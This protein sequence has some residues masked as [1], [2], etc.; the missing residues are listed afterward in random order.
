MRWRFTLP[1]QITQILHQAGAEMMMPD[2][3]DH[4]SRG[5]WMIGLRQPASKGEPASGLGCAIRKRWLIFKWCPAIGQHGGNSGPD[6][7]TRLFVF[8]TTPQIG[9]R[10]TTKIP[11]GANRR[12][13]YQFATQPLDLPF[14]RRDFLE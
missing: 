9:R 6:Q 14:K 2:P 7:W 3:V 4:H 11:K 1:A 13:R 5:Q 8:A 12:R 10:G